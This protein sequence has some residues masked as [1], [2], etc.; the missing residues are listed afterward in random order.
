MKPHT[1]IYM[2]FYG[3]TIADFIG[4]EI[5][6]NKAVDIHHIEARGMGG[7]PQGKKDIIENLMAVCRKCHVE[8]GD[9]PE[10]KETLKK[11]HIKH[12]AIYG[13]QSNGHCGST[14]SGRKRN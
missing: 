5:C 9:V 6:G 1:K 3:Y 12:M 11:V 7:D 14:P 4:C 10:L 8:H 2:D 13:V